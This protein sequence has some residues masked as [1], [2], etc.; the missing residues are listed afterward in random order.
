MLATDVNIRLMRKTPISLQVELKIEA[1]VNPSESS[2]K[3]IHAI[4]NIFEGSLPE[5]KYGSLVTGRCLDLRCL[6]IIYD[7][8]RSRAAL[9]VLRRMLIDNRISNTTWFLLNKQAA[10][11]GVVA[12]MEDESESPLGPIRVKIRCDKLEELVDW[13]AP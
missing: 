11:A 10:F 1:T 3:V 7:Q 6:A 13:L 2:D 4:A 5:L 8:V 9:G 12:V